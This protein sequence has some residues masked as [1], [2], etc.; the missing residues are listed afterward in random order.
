MSL[1]RQ[2]KLE[3]IELILILKTSSLFSDYYLT[4]L[5]YDNNHQITTSEVDL[6]LHKNLF[7]YLSWTVITLKFLIYDIWFILTLIIVVFVVWLQK[8]TSSE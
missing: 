8:E 1:C 2:V 7:F 5:S 6:Q 4:I 3:V